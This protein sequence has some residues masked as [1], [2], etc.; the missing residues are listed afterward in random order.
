MWPDDD[1]VTIDI[2]LII[3]SGISLIVFIGSLLYLF[4]Q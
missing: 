2:A 1:D 4:M 3:L